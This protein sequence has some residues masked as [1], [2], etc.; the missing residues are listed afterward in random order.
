MYT[1]S[2]S[3]SSSSSSLLTLDGW[4]D[5]QYNVIDGICHVTWLK[6]DDTKGWNTVFAQLRKVDAGVYS[7]ALSG[8]R[9][10]RTMREEKSTAQ[11]DA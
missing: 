4:T 2:S 7:N 11:T 3:S 10:N 8:G 9:N 6:L 1:S 5:K